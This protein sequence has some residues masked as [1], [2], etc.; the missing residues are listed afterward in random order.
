MGFIRVSQDKQGFIDEATGKPFVPI[1]VNYA[2]TIGPMPRP[3]G[4]MGHISALFGIDD[5]T[6]PDGLAEGKRMIRRI[7]DLGLNV[8]RVWLEPYDFFPVG[9]RLAPEAAD[10]L[11][12]L[13]TCAG[14]HDV[15]FVLNMH[16][17]RLYTG[18]TFHQDLFQPPHHQ[19]QLEQLHSLARRFGRNENVFSWSIIGE[20]T[21]PWQTEWLIRQWPAF[22]E[23]WY[24]A[25][26]KL[27]K[28]AWGRDAFSSGFLIHSFRDA[29]VPPRPVGLQMPL[30]EF[31][32]RMGDGTLPEDMWAGSTWRYDWRL[33]LEEIGARRVR[34]ESD[35]LRRG[36]AQQMITVGNNVWL[37][38]ALPA[39]WMGAGYHPYFYLDCVDYLCQHNYAFFQAM[40]GFQGDPLDGDE[41]MNYWLDSMDVMGRFYTSMRM[42]VVLEEWGWYGGN[43]SRG[44]VN[45]LGFRTEE[46]QDRFCNLMMETTQ[47]TFAGW[48]NWTWR[49]M[50]GHHDIT[51][52]SGVYA[53]DGTRVKP[54]GKSYATWA[55]KLKAH[56]PRLKPATGAVDVD[57]KQVMTSD[58]AVDSFFRETIS[59]W[60]ADGPFDFRQ[61]YE[62]KPMGQ[63][64]IDRRGMDVHREK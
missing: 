33:M 41:A 4:T 27:L 61:M 53:A 14:E 36:G 48:F 22:L 45:D 25:D 18:L 46:D 57:M 52:A 15:K 8:A 31:A 17:S 26:L 35:A 55:E 3:D 7:A 63:A 59:R 6:E 50:P 58:R 60:R 47:H 5:H 9:E 20:G 49:D 54:W 1:G 39:G 42:P 19:R 44:V 51:N 2:S 43:T 37:H 62:T 29:P 56:P 34:A 12:E 28:E 21:M 32:R 40:A 10:K 13:L 64:P 11:D 30:L 38:P 24:D 16:L 23:Y